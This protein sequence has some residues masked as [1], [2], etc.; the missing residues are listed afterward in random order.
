MWLGFGHQTISAERVLWRKI[1]VPSGYVEVKLPIVGIDFKGMAV[2]CVR[3]RR[4]V[5]LV[6][7]G[8]DGLRFMHGEMGHGRPSV[9]LRFHD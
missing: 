4:L 3:A 1:N 6:W 7:R 2:D 8:L 9:V 5:R